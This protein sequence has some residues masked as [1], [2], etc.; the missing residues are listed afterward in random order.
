MR[1]EHV[2]DGYVDV[3]LVAKG[4]VL[5]SL[6]QNGALDAADS[7]AIDE[8]A[9]SRAAVLSDL[10]RASDGKIYID[11]IAPIITGEGRL[12]ATL[13]FRMDADAFLYPLI[14]GLAF[15]EQKR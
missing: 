9:L 12:A 10:Y 14:E 1:I 8:A 3:L 7:Q 4:R 13:V 2:Y 11:A 15:P 6:S 5:A